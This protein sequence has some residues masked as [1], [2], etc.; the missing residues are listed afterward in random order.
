MRKLI[1]YLTLSMNIPSEWGWDPPLNILGLRDLNYHQSVNERSD[2]FLS[3][4]LDYIWTARAPRFLHT[5]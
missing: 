2:F 1:V 5:V 4:K 3:P